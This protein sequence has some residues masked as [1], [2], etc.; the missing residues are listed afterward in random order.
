MAVSALQYGQG[1][2]GQYSATAARRVDWITDSI[3][4]MLCTSA[5]TPDQDNHTFKSDITNEITGTGYTA[6][7]VTLASKTLTY[8]GASNKLVLDAA[9]VSWTTAT[10]TA[11]YAVIYKDTGA[12]GTSPVLGYVDFGADQVVSAATFAITWDPDGLL[13]AVAA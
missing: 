7:G 6:G 3:K 2:L 5:Y 1:V 9:D 10:F 11:R 8:T 13:K 12:A 4:V